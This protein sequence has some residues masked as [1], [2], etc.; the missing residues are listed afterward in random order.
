L[1]G[2]LLAAPA[3]W[4][5][6]VDWKQVPPLAP[7]RPFTPPKPARLALDG[8]G[9]LLV[10]ENHTLPLVTVL[11][12]MRGAGSAADP[13]GR[14]GLA[15][16]TANLL[17]EGAGGLGAR[18]LAEELE[19][20][21]SE[22]A[23]W[24]EDDAGFVRLDTL[25][26]H[27]GPSLDLV[28]KVISAPAFED[29]EAR[30][31]HEDQATAIQLRRDRPGAVAR[32]IFD[33][34][35]FGRESP[36]GR[37]GLGTARDFG[38]V[39]AA[40]ARAFYRDRWATPQLLVVV[41]GDVAPADARRLVERALA[42]WS[43][44]GA[45]GPP[46]VPPAEPPRPRRGESR[47]HV[48]DRRDAEQANVI[49]GAVGV[50]RSDPEAHPLE[51]L[52]N[53]LGGTYTSRLNNRLR[54]Q[55]GY[56]YGVGAAASYYHD[57]GSIVVESA[58]ATPRTPDGLAE[59]LRIVG[60]TTRTAVPAEELTASQQ[61]LVRGL[62]LWFASNDDIADAFAGTALIGL[63]DDWFDGY[64]ARVRAVTAA[65]VQAVARRLLAAERLVAV[66]VGPMGTL[67]GSLARLGFG[68]PRRYDP[69][70]VPKRR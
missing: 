14:S 23:T 38:R 36:H 9:T 7:E 55:L 58:I 66:V 19:N 26:Q 42:G 53:L 29:R 24:V 15:A 31:I 33:A 64:A 59:I 13:P 51:V 22:L 27:L 57:T 62:P 32:V 10:I 52:L 35:L 5:Q 37:P 41:A 20:L 8:G 69:D 68:R 65:E 16:Y 46:G 56:T 34:A 70:G 63:P 28:G 21:G 48:V 11:F 44:R 47:L 2:I 54:E 49:V 6:P 50:R 40:D 3:A 43:Q 18:E 45:P 67:E 60:E 25:A 39:T 61:N 12:A 1:L 17:D 30:R 4:A